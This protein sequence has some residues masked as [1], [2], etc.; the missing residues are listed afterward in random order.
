M[1]KRT[2]HG[3]KLAEVLN[4]SI[5]TT[6]DILDTCCLL[7]RAARSYGRL[8]ITRCNRELTEA[9]QKQEEQLEK[10]IRALCLD[11]P[12]VAGKPI[13]PIL[14]GDP[15]GAAVKLRM[16]DGRTDDFGGEGLIVPGS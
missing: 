10:R 6:S 5:G 9:E 3:Y 11:L 8:Q 4:P 12:H 7:C 15:R 1:A 13:M 2:L 16:A 14:G